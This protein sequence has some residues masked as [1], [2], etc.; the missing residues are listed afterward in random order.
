MIRNMDR[1]INGRR[2]KERK[3]TR[4]HHQKKGKQK[5]I[6]LHIYQGNPHKEKEMKA[7]QAVVAQRD[8]GGH[9]EEL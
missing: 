1:Y 9:K 5:T 8:K 2:V 4:E 3:W 7:T 6:L